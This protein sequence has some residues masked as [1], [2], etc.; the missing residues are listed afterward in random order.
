[1]STYN[2]SAPTVKAAR[3]AFAKAIGVKTN[4]IMASGG[5]DGMYHLTVINYDG[6]ISQPDASV[7]IIPRKP[8][9]IA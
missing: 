6:P 4:Q 5:D 9:H 3:S 7:T 8:S 1:M 2:M